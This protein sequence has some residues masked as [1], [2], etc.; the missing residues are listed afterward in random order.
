MELK[1]FAIYDSKAEAFLLPFMMKTKG[2]AIRAITAHVSDPQHNFYKYAEDFTLFEL[3]TFNDVN[4][5]Y[6]LLGTPHSIGL[7]CE[8]KHVKEVTPNV[9]DALRV[10][11]K[12]S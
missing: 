1:V 5:K 2:E 10:V 3:G 8:F 6:T 12:S 9:M 7:L 11:E 4:A